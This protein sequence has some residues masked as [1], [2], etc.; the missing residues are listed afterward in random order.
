M[1]NIGKW[2]RKRWHLVLLLSASLGLRVYIFLTAYPVIHTDS[3]TYF[4]LHELGTVRTPGYPLFIEL[5]LSIND[6]LSV[7]GDYLRVIV[8]A[9]LFVLGV[10]NSYLVYKITHTLTS[11]T[12][13]SFLM[14]MVYNFN[15]VVVSFEFQVMTET[16]SISLLLAAI[17]GYLQL[18]HSKKSSA[19]FAGL[20]AFFL[21][22]TRPIYLLW[23]LCLPFVTLFVFY[24]RSQNRNFWKKMAPGVILFVCMNILG[25]GAWA[26]RNKIQYDYFGISSLMPLQLR[27]Y[28]N[29]LFVKYK[30]TDNERLNR[31]AEIYAEEFRKSGRSSVTVHNFYRRARDELKLTDTQI[32][33]AF[34]KV[35]LNLIKDYPFDYLKQVPDSIRRYYMQYSSYWT[36]KNAQKLLTT[37]Q[38]IPSVYRFF[39]EFYRKLFTSLPFLIFMMIVAPIGLFLMVFR[40]KDVLHGWLIV[41]LTLHY[42]CLVSTLTTSAGIVNF[43]YRVPAEP[44][45]LLLFYAFFLYA[46]KGIIKIIRK[47][48]P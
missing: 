45:I 23:G 2:L 28:T 35:N 40:K 8:F 21:W 46:G 15:Y 9:Q 30:P 47:N 7:S 41:W 19:V 17:L 6:L 4:F 16:L 11:R 39:F 29:S 37:K 32:S 43:R 34:L 14:G 10:L 26:L 27:Y 33:S 3:I 36:A 24:P 5:V 1:E 31:I 18:F 48:I 38:P 44:L 12:H 22:M 42:N 13:F 20:F 25:I